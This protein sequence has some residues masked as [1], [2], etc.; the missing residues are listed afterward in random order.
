MNTI[1]LPTLIQIVLIPLG[2]LIGIWEATLIIR[3]V[4]GA[5]ENKKGP[6]ETPKKEDINE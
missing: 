4:R 1:D 6:I 5:F 3:L 2:V